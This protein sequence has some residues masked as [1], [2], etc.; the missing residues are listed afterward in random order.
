LDAGK[1]AGPAQPVLLAAV[2]RAHGLKGEVAIHRFNPESAVLIAGEPVWIEGQGIPSRWMQIEALKG[3]LLKFEGVADRTQAEALRGG[4][5][6]V[7]RSRLPEAEEGE[8]YL[9]DLLGYTVMDST[10]RLLG[11][12]EGLLV[13]GR[14]EYFVIKG[15]REVLLPSES[16]LLASVDRGQ[17][18]LQL[19]LEVDPEELDRQS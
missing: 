2:S 18:T 8:A 6:A 12:F 14:S 15:V 4:Q 17:K 10:G 3:D 16:S 1:S 19:T 13:S 7:D 9:H 11:R 5:L